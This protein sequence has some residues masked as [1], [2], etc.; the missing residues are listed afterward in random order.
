MGDRECEG[1]QRSEGVVSTGRDINGMGKCV[2]FHVVGVSEFT[3]DADDADVFED[4]EA[5]E[6][7]P[8]LCFCPEY[9]TSTAVSFA[10]ILLRLVCTAG[11]PRT[12]EI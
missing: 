10:A 12:V 1:A 11:I 7:S 2:G 5:H 8:A 3:R 6:G 4:E 9:A